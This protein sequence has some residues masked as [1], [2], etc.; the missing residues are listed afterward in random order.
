MKKSTWL[1]LAVAVVALTCAS[2][3]A[4]QTAAASWS[5]PP[6]GSIVQQISVGFNGETGASQWHGIAS[7]KLVGS[8]N[9]QKFYQWYLSIYALRNGAY[10][11]RY[12]SPRNGGPLSHVEQADGAKMWF[13]VQTLRIVG[14][15][16]L[17]HPGVRQLVVQSQEMAAD[18]GSATVTVFATK[19]G[20]GVGPVATVTNSCDL[21]ATIAADGTSIVLT[22]PYY[23]SNAPLCCPTKVK[24]TA[25]LRYRSGK[26]V[27]SP[28]YF[29]IE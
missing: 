21:A 2:A 24:A 19:A 16:A 1:L 11:L 14:T 4:A 20:G 27:E 6:P 28:N 3:A 29:K 22:G 15:A 7:K 18:C 23:A 26:W 10:R 17:T 13:P 5:P 9:G 12:Q 8:G 25:S